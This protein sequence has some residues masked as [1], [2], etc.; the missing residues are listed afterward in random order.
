MR[1]PGDGSHA[2]FMTAN[3]IHIPTG[4]P[5]YLAL[6]SDDVI[7]S[8]WVPQLAG[9]MDMV[10]SRTNVTWL[11]ADKVG[12]FRGQCSEFCGLYIAVDTGNQHLA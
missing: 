10:P 5:V 1:Y 7:H 6:S 8:F 12:D 9:K 3:E 4:R 11:E 2:E